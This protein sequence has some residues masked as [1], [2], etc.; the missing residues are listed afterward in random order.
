MQ[1]A[2]IITE[3]FANS[4]E[5]SSNTLAVSYTNLGDVYPQAVE[6]ILH[7]GY[8]GGTA[9]VRLTGDEVT[10]L[11]DYLHQLAEKHAGRQSAKITSETFRDDRDEGGQFLMVSYTNWGDPYDEGVEIAMRYGEYEQGVTV[12]LTS[13]GV[14]CLRT[15]LDLLL[16]EM[17]R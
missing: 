4:R 10:R 12:R 8:S 6:M 2:K 1:S 14:R 5:G 3:T 13:F 15:H 7:G 9:A 16:K 11:R 17:R